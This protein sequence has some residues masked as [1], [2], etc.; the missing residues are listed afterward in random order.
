MLAIIDY[1]FGNLRSAQKAF[2]SLGA[3]AVITDDERVIRSADHVMLPGVGAFR[4][5]IAR[6]RETGLDRTVKEVADAGTPLLGVCLGMQLM[7]EHSEENGHYDGLGLLPGTVTRFPEMG[8]KVP[9]M[10]WNSIQ[11]R[12]CSLFR[13]NEQPFVYFVHSYCMADID[14]AFTLATAEYGIP[15]TAA[16]GRDNI[17][18]TQFH[19]EKSGDAGLEMLRRFLA[20]DGREAASC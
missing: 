4:D 2:E 1:G 11:V 7:F 17:V 6:L 19:P 14:P 9:H 8:L 16:A 12:P 13:E 15:F 20:W 5:A 18:A 10:G 3:Q